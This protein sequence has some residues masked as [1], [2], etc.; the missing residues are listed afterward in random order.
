MKKTAQNYL[1]DIR[2][3]VGDHY[4]HE[5][6]GRFKY[7]TSGDYT[8]VYLKD[9]EGKEIMEI[10]CHSVFAKDKD[11]KVTFIF[12]MGIPTEKQ[13]INTLKKAKS[14]IRELGEEI[15]KR[16][17]A[18]KKELIKSLRRQMKQLKEAV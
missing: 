7:Y 13:V 1:Q 4:V 2:R 3:I 8:V 6:H 10:D 5:N 17:L 18:E 15:K 16:K 9:K 14:E 11:V 12:S